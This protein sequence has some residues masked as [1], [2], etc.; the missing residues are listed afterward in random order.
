M[1]AEDTFIEEEEDTWYAAPN[2][3]TTFTFHRH[4]SSRRSCSSLTG[5]S[6]LCIE[7]FD[8]SDINFRPCPCGYQVRNYARFLRKGKL[9]VSCPPG[10]PVLFQQYQEQHEWTVSCLPTALR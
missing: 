3:D 5:F 4:L 10:L 1:A 7:E 2:H 6:P 9:T 8:L